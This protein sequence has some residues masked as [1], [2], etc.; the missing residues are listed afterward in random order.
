MKY[1]AALLLV[2]AA[3]SSLRA[4][5][6]KGNTIELSAV[7]RFLVRTVAMVFDRYLRIPRGERR[8]SRTI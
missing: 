6:I 3:C 2:L 1:L 4:L 5:E 8:F 7:G